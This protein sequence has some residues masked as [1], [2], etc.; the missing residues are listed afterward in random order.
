MRGRIIGAGILVALLLG[1][2]R[3]D[4]ASSQT[5]NAAELVGQSADIAPAP[6]LSERMSPP[7]AESTGKLDP[8]DA[9]CKPPLES[10]GRGEEPVRGAGALRVALG[11][12]SSRQESGAVVVCRPDF[13]ADCRRACP[14]ILPRRHRRQ[15]D[16]HGGDPRTIKEASK[17][18][19]SPDGRTFTYVIPADTWGVVASL[20]GS[21]PASR[22][23]CPTMRALV[24]D[25]WKRLEIEIE[26]GFDPATAQVDHG[27]SLEC[28]DGLVADLRPLPGDAT[29]VLA[30]PSSWQSPG[31]D[32]RHGVQLSV[33]YLGTSRWRKVWP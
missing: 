25:V 2:M 18:E 23:A 9:V 29:T 32:G 10:A 14:D 17:P 26:W 5:V 1:S 19:V 33:L 12:S 28:Y 30:G 15:C 6:M 22:F 8:A 4:R 27:G 7:A 20:R 24:S 31:G 21:R 11:G 16:I 3:V 13:A